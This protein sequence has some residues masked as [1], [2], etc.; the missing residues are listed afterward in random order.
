M[1]GGITNQLDKSQKQTLRMHYFRV[2]IVHNSR[3]RIV[4]TA[5]AARE[6]GSGDELKLFIAAWTWR[7]ESLTTEQNAK[8]PSSQCSIC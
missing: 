1:C 8:G 5:C 2:Q 3:K 4:A 7:S 6:G